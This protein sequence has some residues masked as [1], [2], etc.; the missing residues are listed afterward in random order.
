MID[1]IFDVLPQIHGG[2]NDGGFSP[3][4][5]LEA[6]LTFLDSLATKSPAEIFA[7]IMPG[8]SAMDNIHP[9]L[10]HFPIALF[11]LF[12][13]A[14]TLGGLFSKL[15]WRRFATPLLYLGTLSAIVTVSAGFQAAYSVL[16]N[17][18]THAIMLRH[19]AF[20]ISVTV[21]ALILSL[22]RFFAT[23][24]FLYT[25][26]YGH[27]FLSGLLVLLLTLGADLGG[28]MVYHYGVAV[29][30]VMEKNNA[31]RQSEVEHAHSHNSSAPHVHSIEINVP[32]EAEESTPHAHNHG[33][34]P[35]S[36]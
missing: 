17:D 3:V 11:S 21:I 19:Q 12:F 30:P 18:A 20:G 16:H 8:I 35:H 2:G 7:A 26:T 4:K 10:V 5:G 14:D 29:A 25:K 1:L 36:H 31:P 15:T 24:S 34:H 28:F 27:F 22:R 13:V 6:F 33:G 9:L 32:P 23:D